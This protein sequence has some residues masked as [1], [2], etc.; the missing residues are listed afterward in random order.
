MTAGAEYRATKNLTV[1]GAFNYLNTVT[2][3]N[4]LSRTHIELNA[5]QGGLFASLSYPHFFVD[6]ALTY[7]TN[8]VDTRRPGVIDTI[9]GS[10]DGNTFT[11]AG[12]TGYLFDVGTV[13]AGPIAEFAYANVRV[14]N[15]AERGDDLLT[16]GV[17]SQNFNGLTGGAG[18][19]I[20]TALQA[21]G[22]I[23]SPYVNLTAEHDFLGGLRT[24]TSF[25]TDAPLLLFNTSGGAPMNNVLW[26]GCWRF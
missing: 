20:W 15:Y 4:G 14:G 1:G 9:T 7:G 26:E 10:P 5:F 16:L 12:R 3:L 13:K 22:G 8:K 2:D 19:Q 6:G 21:F 18:F 23:F 25:N 11:R 17:Q 24:I